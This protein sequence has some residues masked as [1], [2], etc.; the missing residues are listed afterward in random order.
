MLI[1][2]S[3]YKKNGHDKSYPTLLMVNFLYF[4]GL[5]TEANETFKL[6][7]GSVD[8]NVTVYRELKEK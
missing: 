3:I 2:N 7:I 5:K 4:Q 8:L 1:N 6:L